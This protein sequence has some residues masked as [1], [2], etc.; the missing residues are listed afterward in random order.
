MVQFYGTIAEQQEQIEALWENYPKEFMAFFGDLDDFATP[1][2]YLGLEFF[3]Y[4]PL[5]LGIFAVLIGS[6]LL[7]GDEESGRL[8]LILA[9]PVS[10]AVFYWGRVLAFFVATVAMLA[11]VWLGL[12]VPARWTALSEVSSVEMAQPFVSLLGVLSFFGCLAL[13]LSMV[14]PSRRMAASVTGLLLVASFFLTSLARINT[15]LETA[16]K[17]SPLNYYQGGE[18]I[19]SL[20]VTWVAG[21]L[22][23]A[24]IMA[25]LAAWRFERRDIRVG[26]EGG[27]QRPDLR[28]LVRV[29]L[30]RLQV[31]SERSRPEGATA[32]R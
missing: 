28:S 18:A 5:V 26:G 9:H 12:A 8:D 19:D 29:S 3:S 6:G 16:A 25:L 14:L 22:A 7:V 24:V 4:M 13:L 32:E 10:R 30:R 17:L 20:N 11:I 2:G 27:W 21:L 23:F 15:D 1:S 31:R